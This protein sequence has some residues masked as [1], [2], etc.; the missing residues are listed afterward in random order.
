MN[1]K[2]SV[3]VTCYNHEK[4]IE[5]CLR[6]IFEQTYQN[7]ELIIFNDGST[8]KSGEIISDLI[9]KSPF[10]ETKYLYDD[11]QGVVRVRN[12]ALDKVTGDYLLFVDSD[13]FL[14]KDHIE[15]LLKEAKKDDVDIVYCQLWDFEEK[16]N[17]LQ[18]DLDFSLEKELV[19][20]LI[21]MSSLVKT[22]IIG[23][24][25]FDEKLKNLEDYDFWINLILNNKAIPRFVRD[26]KLNYRVLKDSR[27]QHDDWERY[28]DTYLYILGKYKKVLGEQY[29]QVIK[30]NLILGVT[31]YIKAS[32][33]AEERLELIRDQEREL[34]NKDQHIQN[35]INSKNY[36]IGS[37]LVG[38]I[39]RIIHFLKH[40][41]LALRI[42]KKLAQLIVKYFHPIRT[43]KRNILSVSR[44]KARDNNNYSNPKRVLIYVIYSNKEKLQKYKLIFLKALAA[45]SEQIVIVVNGELLSEDQKI[46][47][48]FGEV[49]IRPNKG[50]D[51][52]AF[53][54]G[55][56]DLGKSVL[57]Q[58]DELL[59]VN[60]TNVGPFAD[61]E[62]IFRKMA[63]R[64][65]DFWGVS[66]GEPQE[67]F[68]GYNKYG[69]IPSH[70]QSY[71]LVIEK[72]LFTYPGFLKYWR[73]LVDTNSRNKAIGRHETVFTK[74]FDDLGFKHGAISGNND[75]SAMYIHPLTMLKEF[76]VPLVK[77]A[78]FSNYDNDKFAWKG[79]SRE[80]E[81]PDLIDYIKKNTDY[82]DSVIDELMYEVKNKKAKEHILII[83][84]VENI[85]PQCTRYRV[86]NKAE[87]LRSL[88][89]EVWTVNASEFKMDYAENASHIIIYRT[90]YSEQFRKLC[91]LAQ[92][93]NKPVYY[94]IDDLVIDT[95]YTNLLSYTQKLS[96]LEKMNYDAG[97]RSYGKM[98]LL[99][100]AVITTTRVLKEELQ[101]YKSEV[102][103]NRNLANAE[104][105]KISQKSLKDYSKANSII[106]IG[107]FSGSITHNENFE[108]I[109]PAIMQ[110]LEKYP[111][112]ELHL[113]GHINLPYELQ[114]FS[115]Q[116][117]VNKYV[118][119]RELPRLIGQ[120]DIN[121]A[122]LVDNVFNQAKSE[123]KWLEAALVKVPTL[124][125]NLGS[126]NEM[127]ENDRTGILASTEE[128]YD[129][130]EMLVQ[131]PEKRR[132]IA[133]KA[134]DFVLRNCVVKHH[135]DELTNIIK[136]H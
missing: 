130:L 95:K 94:D 68:T 50:Y 91:V 48:S 23:N 8:D 111:N 131:N 100:D 3:V 33:L 120:M 92:K 90:G 12:A 53:R 123:I 69:K 54:Y 88:G 99:C 127:I 28:F 109:K 58:Y 30:Q 42:I 27:S 121:L 77:Y 112:V 115:K 7:I 97:V 56:L 126:F 134:H 31:N 98:M 59:L 117:K 84:G 135:E 6:S 82:P 1:D 106:K 83:D 45:L 75:D 108:M 62:I 35:I 89:Y 47:E 104:L 34:K 41:K 122:P 85:I 86:E 80:T 65:L 26:T 9:Q 101:N 132:T 15:I 76:G 36:K 81:V 107:Y 70:L 44:K 13:N 73:N 71:F 2:I 66:Y 18:E 60:D 25:R 29:N 113:V 87:Q 55:I 22:A 52:A 125:S 63:E 24:V 39:K 103:L 37:F 79:L 78:A 133:E 114:K 110:V 118:D 57:S 40:P 93:Y 32:N 119:W 61:L 116:I 10:L 105:V 38:N 74:H 49:K 72:S 128:W 5:K 46:L 20:N 124:A 51:T 11:N 4:Y 102:L 96:D 43:I 64:Q 136:M 129:K 16:H 17:V 67:D 14:N 21:D 19:G